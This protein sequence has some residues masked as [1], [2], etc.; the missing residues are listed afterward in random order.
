MGIFLEQV[1]LFNR[2]PITLNVMFDG[3]CKALPPG[4]TLVPGVVVSY[5]KN[6]N[7]VMGTQDPYNPHISGAEY[8]VGVVGS[9]DNC[10]PLTEE[11]WASHLGQPCR[12]NIQQWFA[13]KYGSDPK[14]KLVTRGKGKATTATSRYDAGSSPSGGNADFSGKA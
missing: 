5:A 2:A 14:A 12:E 11:E 8:L 3:Q 6:Q 9:K 10:E 13:D 1:E 7:P 4:K